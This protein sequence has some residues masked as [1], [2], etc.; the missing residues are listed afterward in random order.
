MKVGRVCCLN[1]TTFFGPEQHPAQHFTDRCCLLL[2]KYLLKFFETKKQISRPKEWPKD[3]M[4]S[5]SRV[6]R[7]FLRNRDPTFLKWLQSQKQ[8]N[9]WL[10][11]GN[12]CY[13]PQETELVPWIH[14]SK[15]A[16]PLKRFSSVN[17][18]C[19]LSYHLLLIELIYIFQDITLLCSPG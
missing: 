14:H 13:S 5:T 7:M 4:E 9:V 16:Q 17:K 11:Y 12:L 19:S 2:N 10:C 1:L 3:Y 6:W 18:S 15:K 8:K